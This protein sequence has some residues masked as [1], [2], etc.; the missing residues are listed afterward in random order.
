MRWQ[1]LLA[2]GRDIQLHVRRVVDPPAPPILLLHGLGVGGAVWQA[3]ARR[4]SPHLAAIAPD[5]RG[6][7]QSDA[8][9]FGYAPHDYAAD[10]AELIEDMV[11]PPLPV[12]GHSLGALV[13]L[14]LAE[15]YPD[16]VDKLVLLDP[17]VDPD[18]PNREVPSV[19]RLRHAP[20]GELE[21]YLLSRDPGGGQMLAGILA[22][23][24]RQASDAAF[25]ALLDADDRVGRSPRAGQT[26]LERAARIQQ[27]TLVMQADPDH[28]GVLGD[29]AA[30]RLVERLPRGKLLKIAGA[31][32]ALHASHPAEVAAAILEFVGYGS[33][34]ASG[35]L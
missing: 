27:P 14:A 15:Q 8:P 30:Q 33:S 26:A 17:P 1:E 18:R 23:L 19:F 29:A 16:L 34:A 2:P 25:E 4:L 12:A 5:L 22:N 20:P 13:G 10:L 32:H 11:E 7:G 6:H 28:G 9:P 21:A 3:F 31:T 24:F 35:S